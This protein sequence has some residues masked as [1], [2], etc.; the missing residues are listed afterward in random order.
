MAELHHSFDYH[1]AVIQKLDPDEV[2]RIVAAEGPLSDEPTGFLAFEQPISE[3][4][5]GRVVR[6][7]E[8]A[9]VQDTRLD[10]DYL[11][12]D[13]RVDPG[14]Q[15]G[16]PIRVGGR[17]WGVLNIEQ[18][19]THAL[20]DEDLMLADTVAALAGAALHRCEL[21][22]ELEGAFLTTLGVLS[23]A[24]ELKDG[25]T[26]AHAAEV[27]NLAEAVGRRLGLDGEAL[28]LV[29]YAALLHDVGKVSV[30]SE[31]LAKPSALTTEEYEEMKEH[32]A[33]GA[34]MLERIPMFEAVAPLVSATHE[35]CDGGGYPDGLAGEA[36]PIGA[37][38]TGAG[39]AYH[40]MTS[41]RPFAGR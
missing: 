36:I 22:A 10:P 4:V 14:S 11:R 21:L 37:R 41:D 30:R 17:I 15:L 39:D 9:V 32:S 25:Y 2:L 28:R 7:G 6:T 5:N 34:R 31:L 18:V 3:G 40:A 24:V 27:A 35:R 12:R 38:I 19:A 1:L 26:G 33:A 23:D 20:E 13:P 16:L 8:P 29:G